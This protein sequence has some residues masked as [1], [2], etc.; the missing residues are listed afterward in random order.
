MTLALRLNR[1][2]KAALFVIL[3]AAGASLVSGDAMK[4]GLG[5]ILLGVAFAW[6]F[7]SDSR[8]VHSLF[9]ACGLLIVIG[10]LMY[11]WHVHREKA[12]LYRDQVAE[13]ERKIPDFAKSYPVSPYAAVPSAKKQ[14][15][16]PSS[17]YTRVILPDGSCV[18]YPTSMGYAEIM[19]VTQSEH[20]GEDCQAKWYTD[21]V[22]AGVEIT[23]IQKEEKPGN[24]KKPPE[25]FKL[26]RSA[27]KNLFLIVPGLFQLFIGMGLLWGVK[28][29]RNKT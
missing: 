11:D 13:F 16:R 6:A 8:V 9:L 27:R 18:Y 22:A 24:G 25:P 12:R 20:G 15:A 5:I 2:H 21:A 29:T 23:A 10:T 1:R 17:G 4:I 28:P 3:V 14:Q 7:G 26:W 19:D